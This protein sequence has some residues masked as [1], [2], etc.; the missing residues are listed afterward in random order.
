VPIPWGLLTAAFSV[1]FHGRLRAALRD[2][3]RERVASQ[4]AIDVRA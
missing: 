1:T 4:G 2:I 3:E